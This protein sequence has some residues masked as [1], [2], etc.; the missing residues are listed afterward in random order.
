M[1]NEYTFTYDIPIRYY[2][3]EFAIDI[4]NASS[5][6][7]H[8]DQVVAS[9]DYGFPIPL[10]LRL[11]NK[12]DALVAPTSNRSS[13]YMSFFW[14]PSIYGTSS[15][16]YNVLMK[17]WWKVMEKA[18]GRPHWGKIYNENNVDYIKSLYSQN[19]KFASAINKLDP[20]QKF[21]N[22]ESKFFN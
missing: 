11:V 20:Q 22:N 4:N 14:F 7:H 5:T 6:L 13:L 9:L 19:Q 12:S 1:L 2:E 10:L 15:E 8:I 3:S 16:A 17:Q 18:K 21:T